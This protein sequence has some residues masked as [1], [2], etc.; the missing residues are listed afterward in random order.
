MDWRR[1]KG[2]LAEALL[3]FC[4]VA[5]NFMSHEKWYNFSLWRT[6]L[7]PNGHV[8][9]SDLIGQVGTWW[10]WAPAV[11]L[12]WNLVGQLTWASAARICVWAGLAQLGFVVEL[13]WACLSLQNEEFCHRWYTWAFINFVREVLLGGWVI[14]FPVSKGFSICK[15]SVKIIFDFVN[16]CQNNIWAL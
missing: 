10:E 11:K 6:G 4:H 5:F 1:K 9:S 13:L 3:A 15:T 7:T 14:I 16:M 12:C 8:S 2:Q